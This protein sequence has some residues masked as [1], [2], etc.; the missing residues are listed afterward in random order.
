MGIFF[1]I[2]EFSIKAFGYAMYSTYKNGRCTSIYLKD[3]PTIR[4]TIKFDSKK[5]K[6]NDNNRD[7]KNACIDDFYS[8]YYDYNFLLSYFSP[9]ELK[10]FKNNMLDFISQE[11]KKLFPVSLQ[12]ENQE[13]DSR[14]LRKIGL[15]GHKDDIA[16][17]PQMIE[18][19]FAENVM[20][21]L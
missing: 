14:Y 17:P 16:L 2:H 13:I 19:P 9:Q 11:E 10:Q 5:I 4:F 12:K 18:S 21:E 20:Y 6:S 1:D 7:F 3:G 15:F 8:H